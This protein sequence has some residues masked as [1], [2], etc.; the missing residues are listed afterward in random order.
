[1]L[2]PVADVCEHGIGLVA[3]AALEDVPSQVTVGLHVAD[4]AL[5]SRASLQLAFDLAVDA[6]LLAGEEHPERHGRIVAT[7]ALVGVDRTDCLP[8]RALLARMLPHHPLGPRVLPV[9][10]HPRS[11][12]AN[13]GTSAY[14]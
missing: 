6:T 8:L 4:G 13:A 12:H 5:N 3:L 11:T 10:T 14:M 7:I 9:I 2:I 1:M